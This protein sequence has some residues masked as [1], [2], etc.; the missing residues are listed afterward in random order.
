MKFLGDQTAE[1]KHDQRGT[2]HTDHTSNSSDGR[3][4]L[5]DNAHQGRTIG[6]E[7][8]VRGEFTLAF[9]HSRRKHRQ[10]HDQSHSPEHRD[11]HRHIADDHLEIRFRRSRDTARIHISQTFDP[12]GFCDIRGDLL[13]GISVLDFDEHGGHRFAG[14]FFRNRGMSDLRGI[15]ND[16]RHRVQVHEYGIVQ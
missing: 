3:R 5:D 7:N 16:I 4:F 1:R 12:R 9:V 15:G 6:A 13:C 14:V 8:T 11:E 10:H 2:G